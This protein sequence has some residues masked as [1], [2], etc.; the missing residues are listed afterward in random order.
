MRGAIFHFL[1][2]LGF[3]VA[4]D[5]CGQFP[6]VGQDTIFLRQGDRLVGKL[7]GVDEQS[8]RLRR[9]LPPLPGASADVAPVFA[10]VT[11]LRSHVDRVEFSS[12]E[13]Q[14]RVLKHATPVNASEI[15]TLWR[16]ARPWLAVPKSPAGGIGISY[17]DL[18]L[19]AGDLP[20]A[21]KALE[22]FRVIETEAWSRPDAMRARQGR[23]R[24]MVALG[25]LEEAIAEARE[26]E[27]VAED[28]AV[29]IEAKFILA[30]AAEKALRKLEEDNPRW[31]EDAFV[32]PERGRLYEETLELYLYPA[33]FFGSESDAASRG[34]WGAAEVSRF[35]GDLKQA[36]EASRD[37]VAIYPGTSHARQAQDFI[38]TLPE[39]LRKQ[40]N[41]MEA[42]R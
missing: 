18:L 36:L 21:R 26:I 33:L 22:L 31:Q 15:E 3:L 37:L 17:G 38:D 24:A 11:V 28:P 20:S 13:A 10:S 7:T 25:T 4:G 6:Q 29:L 5:A 34:L 32:A 27:R 2:L 19:R 8:I 35:A 39:N 9:L 41:E 23:L 14:E 30:K 12:G 42:K 40:Y 16:E 1:S